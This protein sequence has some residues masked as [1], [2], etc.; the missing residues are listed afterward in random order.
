MVA[1][2]LWPADEKEG[3]WVSEWVRVDLYWE[4]RGWGER[5]H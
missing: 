4:D 1:T 5:C 2:I 3:G